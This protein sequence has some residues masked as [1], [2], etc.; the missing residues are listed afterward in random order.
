MLDYLVSLSVFAGLYALLALGLNLV[1]GLGGM[2]NLGLAGFYSIGAYVSALAALHL[3]LALP[4]AALLAAL[5]AGA[6]GAA[7]AVVTSRLKGDYL[8]IVTLGFA[9]VIQ[10]IAANEIWLTN[11]TDGL[12]AIPAPGRGKL[13]PFH[14]DLAAAATV[15]IVLALIALGLVRLSRASYGRVLRAIR[16]DETVARVAGKRV[17]AFKIG[18][19][20]VGAAVMGLAGSLY[21]AYDGYVAPDSFD[22]L[23]TVLVVLALTAGGVGNMAGAVLGSA[24]VVALTE[25]TRFLGG[26]LPGLSA[27]QVASLRQGAIGFFLLLLLRLRP[28]GILP[29]RM[30]VHRLDG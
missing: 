1:W 29:E 25:G 6:A 9:E 14:F 7:L 10:L 17:L 15:W 22:V 28:Q 26:L 8:A 24:L 30:R 3:H 23:V 5:L 13:S 21:A 2:V 16:E 20:A 11:G 27:L 4:L 19:F 12:S 18:A